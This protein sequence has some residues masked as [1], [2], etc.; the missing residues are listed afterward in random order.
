MSSGLTALFKALW[1]Y[2]ALEV[3]TGVRSLAEPVSECVKRF[4]TAKE[5]GDMQ[6]VG[7][8]W[9]PVNVASVMVGLLGG[10]FVSWH[11]GK[12]NVVGVFFL[13]GSFQ[14]DVEKRWQYLG[15][16]KEKGSRKIGAICVG[17]KGQR[18]RNSDEN[19][20]WNRETCQDTSYRKPAGCMMFR[21]VR[22]CRCSGY[23]CLPQQQ[24]SYWWFYQCGTE[25]LGTSGSQSSLHA[26]RCLCPA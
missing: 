5:P 20:W 14:K 8:V 22:G 9:W 24:L 23:F 4:K 13:L 7:A 25:P 10:R 2:S 1:M 21:V 19:N 16:D 12:E 3:L 15:Q 18:L 26:Q 11:R 6:T 17:S